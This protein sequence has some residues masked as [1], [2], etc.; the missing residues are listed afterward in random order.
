MSPEI[1][2]RLLA[3]S[4][5]FKP[6]FAATSVHSA[7]RR[8]ASRATIPGRPSCWRRGA[9]GAASGRTPSR[10]AAARS[11]STRGG[12][13][14][15][16][17]TCGSRSSRRPRGGG[18]MQTLVRDAATSHWV[19][20]FITRRSGGGWDEPSTIHTNTTHYS[21]FTKSVGAKSSAT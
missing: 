9:G 14:T 11:A 10:C 1:P 17:T 21:Q 15:G 19:R 3:I 7:R 8:F 12:R 16:R 5:N 18:C 6:T 4:H 13:S 20:V 2:L